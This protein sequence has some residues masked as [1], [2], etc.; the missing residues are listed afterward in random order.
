MAAKVYIDCIDTLEMKEKWGSLAS[1]TRVARVLGLTGVTWET[2]YQV[3]D[4]AGVPKKGTY[5]DSRNPQIVLT[6]RDVKMIDKDKADVTLSYG[7]F[8]DKGQALFYGTGSLT[9]RNIAGKM[10]TSVTQKET[11]LYRPNGTGAQKP[12]QLQH[13]YP[14]DD[15]DY[16]GQTIQQSGLVQV[17]LPQRT[18][19]IEGVKQVVAPW[20]M[21]ERL[22]R[23]TNNST[24]LG[25]PA[26]T[27][28]CTE[29]MWEFREYAN[30]FMAFTFQHE[31][32]GW[33]P[34][35]VFIDDRTNR[36]PEGV[37]VNDGSIFTVPY[38]RRV[39]FV[40]ELGFFVIGPN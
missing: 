26:G 6:D 24:W 3:L 16:G 15:P 28:M 19:T 7:P 10:T 20:E 2:M 34:T 35:A 37:S 32:D 29:V 23:A 38:F 22:I 30:Y 36:P 11:N 27:W 33:D 13:T 12:I 4:A 31:E 21:A 8:N 25:Q 9:N 5:L 40:N 39:S 1:V 17:Q 14:D 18:F